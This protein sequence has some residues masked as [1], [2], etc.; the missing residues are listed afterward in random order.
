MQAFSLEG[1]GIH[2]RGVK[3]IPW[4][5]QSWQEAPLNPWIF[6][7]KIPKK[8]R[9]LTGEYFLPLLFAASKG[10]EEHGKA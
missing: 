3:E 5:R 6:S 2:I 9:I 1:M 4:R 7:T 10:V 8:T